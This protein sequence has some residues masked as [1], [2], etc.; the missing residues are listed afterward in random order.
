MLFQT[1]DVF[2]FHYAAH[3]SAALDYKWHKERKCVARFLNFDYV[4][5][6]GKKKSWQKFEMG[7]SE[8]WQQ[9]Q[10]KRI[11]VCDTSFIEFKKKI[12]KTKYRD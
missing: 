1:Q 12:N 11:H 2:V 5:G 9:Q 7:Q 4:D 8:F 6:A 3:N 10:Q